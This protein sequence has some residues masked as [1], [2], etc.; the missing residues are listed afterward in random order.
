MFNE[1]NA[2]FKILTAI[3]NRN[4]DNFQKC[5]EKFV[6]NLKIIALF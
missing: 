2:Y 6:G 4:V 1:E 3:K 5:C